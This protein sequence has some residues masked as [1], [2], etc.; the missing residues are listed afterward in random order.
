MLISRRRFLSVTSSRPY[1]TILLQQCSFT[2]RVFRFLRF[3]SHA[4]LRYR[5][6]LGRILY[7]WRILFPHSR[8]AFLIRTCRCSLMLMFCLLSL[9]SPPDTL[10]LYGHVIL[11]HCIL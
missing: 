9:R 5:F 6:Y 4:Y 7:H 8:I 3:Y 1:S 2:L 10:A 11:T